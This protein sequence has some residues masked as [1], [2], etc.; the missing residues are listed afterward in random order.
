MKI[1]EFIQAKHLA[2]DMRMESYECSY[3]YPQT[4]DLP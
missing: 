4:L 1:N 3:Y 2:E